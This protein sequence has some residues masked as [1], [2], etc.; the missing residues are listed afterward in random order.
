[1]GEKMVVTRPMY[2]FFQMQICGDPDLTDEEILD[3]CNREN[4]SGTT[5]GWSRVERVGDQAPVV[6]DDNPNKRHYIIS[7]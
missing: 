6:C 4:P 7:C 1:M 3:F 2:G 5:N